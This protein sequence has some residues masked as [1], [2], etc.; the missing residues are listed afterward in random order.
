ML[1]VILRTKKLM[2]RFTKKDCIKTNQ[3]HFRVKV[4]KRKGDKLYVK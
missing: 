2:E 3:K 4:T 1:L